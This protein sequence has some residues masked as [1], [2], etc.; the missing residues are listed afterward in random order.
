MRTVRHMHRSVKLMAN[1][2]YMIFKKDQS[3]N[4]WSRKQKSNREISG[5]WTYVRS[6]VWSPNGM[7]Y[8]KNNK[9]KSKQTHTHSEDRNSRPGESWEGLSCRQLILVPSPA[10]HKVPWASLAVTLE[11]PS[12]TRVIWVPLLVRSEQHYMGPS[13]QPP[14]LLVKN[15]QDGLWSP[16]NSAL[17]LIKK[18]KDRGWKTSGTF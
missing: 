10:P 13:I 11:G 14:A 15:Y 17:F 4:Q 3:E 6:Q 5:R 18:K 8:I 9:Q 12:T 2:C 16:L 1:K 7:G